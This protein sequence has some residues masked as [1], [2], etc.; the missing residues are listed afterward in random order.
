M[1]PKPRLA[2]ALKNN[3]ELLRQIWEILNDID[4]GYL[5]GNGRVYGGGL[6]KLEPGELA[7][8]DATPIAQLLSGIAFTPA[9]N[10]LELFGN[11]RASTNIR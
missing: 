5:L 11:L 2:Q 9:P 3:P 8:V 1:Y 6:H 7:C 4:A 10:Q